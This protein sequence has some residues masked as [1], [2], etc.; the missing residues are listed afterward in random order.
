MQFG[1]ALQTKESAKF[2]NKK[3]AFLAASLL[4][5]KKVLLTN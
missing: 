1:I 2:E 3:T 4:C 5:P